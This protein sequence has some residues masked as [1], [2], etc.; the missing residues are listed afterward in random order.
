MCYIL[1]SSAIINGYEIFDLLKITLL[2]FQS[3]LF[4]FIIY[5]EINIITITVKIEIKRED[6]LFTFSEFSVL[7]INYII[8]NQ[9]EKFDTVNLILKK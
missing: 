8:M 5:A 4:I 6:Y 2:E 9:R 1:Y 7:L 3:K